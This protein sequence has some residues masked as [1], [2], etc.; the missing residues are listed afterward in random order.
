MQPM[1][2]QQTIKNVCTSTSL[3]S[4]EPAGSL[5]SEY[6]TVCVCVSVLRAVER[7]NAAIRK[8]VAEETVNEL[9]NPDAQLP[10]VYPSAADLYQ[11]ELASLQQ[12]SAEVKTN[13]HP[14]NISSLWLFCCDHLLQKLSELCTTCSCILMV[15][16]TNKFSTKIPA[17][18]FSRI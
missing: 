4:F 18:D 12:Q 10:Q 2:K 1:R 14:H 11:R 13:S 15:M 3:H 8:G 17:L 9:M 7:I 16:A 6:S 5:F